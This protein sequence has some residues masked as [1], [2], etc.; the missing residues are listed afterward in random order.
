MPTFT[1]DNDTTSRDYVSGFARGL[2]VIQAFG[3]E[4][5]QMTLADV[6]GKTGLDRAV[7]RR[8]LH[9]LCREGFARTNGKLFELTPRILTL[10]YS[11]LSSLGLDRKLQPFLDSLSEKIG[12][13]A[14]VSVLDGTETVFIARSDRPSNVMA[15]VVRTGF[16]LPAFTS[17]SG[18]VLL[19]A[20]RDEEIDRLL[21]TTPV[22][23]LTSHT[24]VDAGEI[25]ERIR[26]A[27]QE[28]FAYAEEELEEGLASVAVP[29]KDRRGQTIASI[30]TNC[31]LTR[32][33]STNFVELALPHMR[34]TASQVSELLTHERL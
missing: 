2:R 17:A 25:R 29:V 15:Y 33:K 27:R 13:A 19:A 3:P 31:N 21:A 1:Q 30:N 8:L 14:S 34:A 22:Q 20:L 12:Q 6:A 18:R 4:H 5:P 7:V 32:A 28:G 24:I 26:S 23:S 10:G 11:Y 9:T 16:R